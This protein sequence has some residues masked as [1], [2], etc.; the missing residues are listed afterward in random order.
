MEGSRTLDSRH[1]SQDAQ[2]DMYTKKKEKKRKTTKW[3]G[4]LQTLYRTIVPPNS[5]RRTMI[6]LGWMKNCFHCSHFTLMLNTVKWG[7]TSQ[8][9]C[10]SGWRNEAFHASNSPPSPSPFLTI[11]GCLFL[12]ISLHCALMCGFCLLHLNHLIDIF[13]I[14]DYFNVVLLPR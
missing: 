13:S 9:A 12:P 10:H 11:F 3:C 1:N 5:S 4:K 2:S 8:A 14:A 6:D 7:S